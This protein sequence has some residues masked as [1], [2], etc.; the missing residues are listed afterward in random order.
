MAEGSIH[1]ICDLVSIFIIVGTPILAVADTPE[2]RPDAE[3]RIL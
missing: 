1:N 2:Y 3:T